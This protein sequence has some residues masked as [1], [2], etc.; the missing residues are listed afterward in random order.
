MRQKEE[1]RSCG[2]RGPWLLPDR[3]RGGLSTDLGVTIT[4]FKDNQSSPSDARRGGNRF[5]PLREGY[6]FAVTSGSCPWYPRDLS[7]WSGI[8]CACS[9]QDQVSPGPG[10][11]VCVI[12]RCGLASDKTPG[13]LPM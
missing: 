2:Q 9:V 13:Q 3:G 7:G 6:R 10:L 12:G 11:S 8:G 4:L 1:P 5:A